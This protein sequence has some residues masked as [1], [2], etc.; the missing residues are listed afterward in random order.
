MHSFYFLSTG[1]SANRISLQVERKDGKQ[2]QLFLIKVKS[3]KICFLLLLLNLSRGLSFSSCD[4][5]REK[6]LN[7]EKTT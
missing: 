6:K 3:Q 5:R 7:M 4:R 1:I 2:T